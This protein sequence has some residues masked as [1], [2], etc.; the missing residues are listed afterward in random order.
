[1]NRR[2]FFISLF[3]MSIQSWQL[4]D[5]DA[6]EAEFKR[7]LIAALPTNLQV[8]STREGDANTTP[9]VSVVLNT[10]QNQGQR[11]LL[12]PGNPQTQFQPLNVWFYTL[13]VSV[14]TDRMQNNDRH[15]ELVAKCR[16]ACQLYKLALSWSQA[17][18]TVVEIL[19]QPLVQSFDDVTNHD[20]TMM[21][22]MGMLAI[23]DGA[24]GMVA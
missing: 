8:N 6:C 17:V 24:W 11:Y 14:F 13:N 3:I 4:Y 1:M 7:I 9:R 5:L 2:N 10:Q 22:F 18:F 21:A 12:N 15:A 23:R 20:Q 19:E 16:Q